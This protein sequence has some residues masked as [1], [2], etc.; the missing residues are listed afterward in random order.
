VPGGAVAT[1]AWRERLLEGERK[2][3][4][5]ERRA[6]LAERAIATFDRPAPGRLQPFLM[7]GVLALLAVLAGGYFSI[8]LPLLERARL[9]RNMLQNASA[10]QRSALEAA[11]QQWATERSSL[12]AL[13]THEQ[14]RTAALLAEDRALHGAATS[15]TSSNS[16]ARA[17]R[18]AKLRART[19]RAR[20]TAT[21]SP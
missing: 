3:A 12:Q 19:P 8:H 21:Q 9:Q 7:A 20:Q 14:L 13:L 1:Q 15:A 16:T 17:S 2:L 6:K 18:A 5:A 11:R 4:Q 10:D